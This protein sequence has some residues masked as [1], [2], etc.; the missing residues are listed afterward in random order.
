MQYTMLFFDGGIDR[1]KL[2]SACRDLVKTHDILRT[3]FIEH[4]SAFFQVILDEFDSPVTT[5]RA[6]GDLKQYVSDLC[7]TQIEADFR[8]GS[9]F[10]KLIHVEGDDGQECLTIGL[11]H[12]QYD[13]MSLPRLLQ[14]LGTLY[15]GAKIADFEPFSSYM[16]LVS[17]TGAHTSGLAYWRNLLNASTLS[18]LPGPSTQPTDRA[19]FQTHPVYTFPPLQD[20]TTATLLSAAWAVLL[21]RRLRTT[22]V[23]FASVT[24]GRT[25]DLPNIENVQGPCYQLTP[26]R[27]VFSREWTGLDF[28]R[29]IQNQSAESA[30]HDYVG[31]SAIKEK[32]TQW[33]KDVGVDSIVH[34]QDFED[35]DTMPFGSGECKVDILNPHGDAAA[36]LKAVSFTKGGVLHVGIVGSERDAVFVDVVLKE[37]AA[38][39]EELAV[40]QSELLVLDEMFESVA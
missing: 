22:D 12:A 39:V 4:E 26:L 16:T 15:T 32:C 19:T 23:T 5:H 18:I 35:F 3:V 2:F 28:L 10:F 37:L 17:N 9:S 13:G 33:R 11:S 25:N 31:F 38:V 27:V 14:D 7:N 6:V 24:S 8:L 20:I 36:P 29:F 40:R 1:Q 34:H 21:A 30:A